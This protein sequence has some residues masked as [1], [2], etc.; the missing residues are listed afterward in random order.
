MYQIKYDNKRVRKELKKLPKKEQER[1]TRAIENRLVD[2][3]PRTR[4]IRFVKIT[5]EYSLRQGDYRILF[6]VENDTIKVKKIK[7]RKDCYP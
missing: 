6:V 1:I 2:F 4:G 7:N 5:G 3:T